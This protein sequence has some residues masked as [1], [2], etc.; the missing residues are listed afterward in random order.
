MNLSSKAK[1]LFADSAMVWF[2]DNGYDERFVKSAQSL[3]EIL[4]HATPHFMHNHI[5]YRR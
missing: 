4:E 5:E 1:A 2:E 3:N